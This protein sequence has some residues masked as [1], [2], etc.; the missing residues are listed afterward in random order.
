MKIPLVLIFL[1]LVNKEYSGKEKDANLLGFILILI[2]ILG[3]ATGGRDAL[4]VLAGT[5]SP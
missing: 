3:F 1:Y 5:C 2:A 4:T